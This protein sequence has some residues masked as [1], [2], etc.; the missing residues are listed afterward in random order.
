MNVTEKNSALVFISPWGQKREVVNRFEDYLGSPNH[1][2]SLISFEKSLDLDE[3]QCIPEHE[4]AALNKWGLCRYFVPER[5]DGNL[6]DFDEMVMLFRSI[7]RRDPAIAVGYGLSSF[8]ACLPIWCSG[9]NVLQQRV[10]RII[11]QGGVI[12]VA[13]HE[14]DHGNDVLRNEFTAVPVESGFSLSGE[15][16]LINN[17]SRA[18]GATV[19]AKTD[20]RIQGKN[21]SMFF[22]EKSNLDDGAHVDRIKTVG[23]RACHLSGWAAKNVDVSNDSLIGELGQG[24]EISGKAFQISRTVL[25]GMTVAIA[26][27]A[28]RMAVDFLESRKLYGDQAIALPLV[29]R[30]VANVFVDLISADCLTLATARLAQVAPQELSLASAITKYWVPTTIGRCMDATSVLL[31]ARHYLRKGKYGYFQKL[32]RDASV[33]SIVHASPGVCLGLIVQ[34]LRQLSMYGQEKQ[35]QYAGED[36]DIA[37]ES[38]LQSI[39]CLSDPLPAFDYEALSLNNRGRDIILQSFAL[40]DRRLAQEELNQ[41]TTEICELNKQISNAYD[42]LLADIS[43]KLIGTDMRSPQW[44]DAAKRYSELYAAACCFYTWYYNR[45]NGQ[46]EFDAAFRSG[47]WLAG[48]LNT[49]L[50]TGPIERDEYENITAYVRRCYQDNKTFLL[51]PIRYS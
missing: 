39:F 23:V 32:M 28:L 13:F 41:T 31:G 20:D 27:T 33:V 8:M 22:L 25:P 36:V 35:A 34:Q 44:F 29:Q 3:Q 47:E 10:A 17:L 24:F 16:W 21:Y 43:E 50:Q 30:D 18:V 51:M 9:S 14:K 2:D 1:I 4:Y 48:M 12:S 11:N 6:R 7:F 5:L 49:I 37:Q 42:D 26:D 45:A 19:F 15:K 46:I 38:K 40:V